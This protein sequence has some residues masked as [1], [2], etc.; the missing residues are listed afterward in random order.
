[1]LGYFG[2]FYRA[3]EAVPV[4]VSRSGAP[5]RSVSCRDPGGGCSSAF[6]IG[7][8]L[9]PNHPQMNARST[10][11]AHRL[12]VILKRARL[13]ARSGYFSA[14]VV[15]LADS[16]R[17]ERSGLYIS[18]TFAEGA[19]ASRL[20]LLVRD[21]ELHTCPERRGRQRTRR[22]LPEARESH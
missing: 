8:S 17:P 11:T 5:L 15:T 6:G 10:A 9:R 2:E 7:S 22:G 21:S 4:R 20:L 3:R 14:A 18:S 1:M 12:R 16:V 19:V 13:I